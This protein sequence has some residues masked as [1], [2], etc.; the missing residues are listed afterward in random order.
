M[1][2]VNC[3]IDPYIFLFKINIIFML[4]KSLQKY[5]NIVILKFTIENY[6]FR[7]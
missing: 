4:G 2:R 5:A 7:E 6:Y 1:I 3:P